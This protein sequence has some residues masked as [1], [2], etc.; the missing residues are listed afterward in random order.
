MVPGHE[1]VGRVMKTGSQVKKFKTG[2]RYAIGTSAK[3]TK[4]ASLGL[5]DLGTW[6]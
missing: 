2:D 5:A 3:G 4:S 6:V 1:I